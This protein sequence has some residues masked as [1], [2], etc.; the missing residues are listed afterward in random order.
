MG[1]GGGRR[2]VENKGEEIL[3][4][5]LK[6]KILV[7]PEKSAGVKGIKEQAD[8]NYNNSRNHGTTMV[9]PCCQKDS[10]QDARFR[11]KT[12]SHWEHECFF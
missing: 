2:R 8:D 10:S 9:P 11:C 5:N 12:T 7:P 6:F 3:L 1:E 4:V